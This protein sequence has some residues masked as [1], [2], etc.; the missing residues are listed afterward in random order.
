VVAQNE[1]TIACTVSGD[2]SVNADSSG[3]SAV[4]SYNDCC[5]AAEC[6]IN[7]DGNYFYD[8]SAGAAYSTCVDFDID[9]ACSGQDVAM[10]VQYCMG[11]DG[12]QTY[13]V[14]ISSGTFAVSGSMSAGTGTL[15]VRDANGTYTCTYTDYAG[16]CTDGTNTFDFGA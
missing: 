5:Q 1:Q 15:T 8:T 10:D 2:I 14:E 11:A 9:Y 6:C 7:G 16:S 3:T 12:V 13:V 4:F